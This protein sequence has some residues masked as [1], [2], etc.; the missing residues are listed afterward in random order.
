MDSNLSRFAGGRAAADAE[1]QEPAGWPAGS[2][3]K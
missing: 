1:I 2:L 3:E